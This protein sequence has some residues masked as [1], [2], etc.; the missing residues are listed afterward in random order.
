MS[1]PLTA[2]EQLMLDLMKYM[3]ATEGQIPPRECGAPPNVKAVR[4][5]RLE[6]AFC[7]VMGALDPE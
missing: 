6:A 1:N 3:S 7:A 4:M 2:E 5:D